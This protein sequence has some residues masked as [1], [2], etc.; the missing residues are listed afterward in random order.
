MKKFKAIL[1]TGIALCIGVS[2]LTT[3]FA[4]EPFTYYKIG[5]FDANKKVDV[6][7]V[8]TLQ[9]ELAGYEVMEVGAL[10]MADLNGDG[11]FDVTD[12]T[13]TQKMIAGLDYEC[14]ITADESYN[15]LTTEKRTD[16]IPEE[17]KIEFERLYRLN[18]TIYDSFNWQEGKQGEFLIKSKEE[19]YSVFGVYSPVFDDK[20]FKENALYII[21]KFDNFYGNE[22]EITDMGVN[23][24][25]IYI[26]RK[27]TYLQMVGAMESYWHIFYRV[28]L[29]DIKDADTISYR[30]EI[31]YV[32]NG[33]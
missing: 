19:F 30:Y 24:N 17:S 21:L 2:S 20:F 33:F 10:D 5:D 22:Y 12:V 11:N 18:N 14:F 13:E 31:E 23:G 29:S 7:D 6:S 25:I 9:M 32:D 27:N 28:N 26:D 4:V 16:S 8:T 3:A 1:T 15:N